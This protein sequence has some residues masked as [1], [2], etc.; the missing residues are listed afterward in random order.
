MSPNCFEN[1]VFYAGATPGTGVVMT[2][3]F[4]GPGPA[5]PDNKSQLQGSC[6]SW[7]ERGAGSKPLHMTESGLLGIQDSERK[8]AT[9][10]IST[11]ALI[12]LFGKESAEGAPE[13]RHCSLL[14]RR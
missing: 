7:A 14:Q 9:R 11:P 5:V 2:W 8:L 1:G 12:L 6:I 10:D 3:A 4:R 13:R